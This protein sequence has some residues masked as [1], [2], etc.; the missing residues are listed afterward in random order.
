MHPSQHS[1]RLS[2]A[3][4]LALLIPSLGTAHA[5]SGPF[6]LSALMS[7]LAQNPGGRAA[8]VETKILPML[9]R[10]LVA[11]GLLR[12]HRPDRLEM[13]TNGPHPQSIKLEGPN[14]RVTAN[15]HSEDLSLRYHPEAAAIV[16]S[17]RGTLAG[18]EN[19]LKAHYVLK[20]QGNEAHWNL[21]LIPRDRV[22]RRRIVSI[23][24]L[25]THGEIQRVLLRQPHGARTILSIKALRE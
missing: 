2:W 9:T 18:D 7:E 5:E 24:V 15:H 3:V 10:P 20:L 4:G 22:A 8:F 12:Y 6:T 17:I 25:G 14:L 11:S 13:D 19:S 16:E 21:R 23:H 1:L